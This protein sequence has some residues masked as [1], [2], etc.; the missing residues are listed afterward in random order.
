[1]ERKVL[2]CLK[3]YL[4]QLVRLKLAPHDHFFLLSLGTSN[5]IVSVFYVKNTIYFYTDM[6][7]IIIIYIEYIN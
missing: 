7:K 4:L 5:V 1:M 6:I 3:F 2:K